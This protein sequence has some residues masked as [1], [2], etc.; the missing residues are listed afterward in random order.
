MSV[1]R[2]EPEDVIG[3]ELLTIG[4]EIENGCCGSLWRMQP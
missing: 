2:T 3:D 1:L 4:V